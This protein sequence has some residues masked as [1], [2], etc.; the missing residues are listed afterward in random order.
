MEHIIASY[1]G[2]IWDKSN[3]LF[4]GQHGFRSGYSLES[5]VITVCQDIASALDNGGRTDVI[6]TDF[7]KAFDLVPHDWLLTKIAASRLDLGVVEW[8]REFFLCF[9]QRVRA[10]R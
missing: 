5:R 7:V 4:K 3:W 8:V 6:I 2:K 9:T 1:L 10:G